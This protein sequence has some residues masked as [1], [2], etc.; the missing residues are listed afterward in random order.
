VLDELREILVTLTD[1]EAAKLDPGV[2]QWHARLPLSD[3]GRRG[4]DG[5][6]GAADRG[7]DLDGGSGVSTP[8]RG[9]RTQSLRTP[10]DRP[11]DQGRRQRRP[12]HNP[13][14]EQEI[15]PRVPSSP[16]RRAYAGTPL[17]LGRR[18]LKPEQDA[19]RGYHQAGREVDVLAGR[20]HVS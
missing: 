13:G 11:L 8:Q 9:G 12:A 3:R 10:G 18:R 20:M 2:I 14:P 17:D 6:R 16:S 1:A 15:T 4:G 7:G 5:G 19:A